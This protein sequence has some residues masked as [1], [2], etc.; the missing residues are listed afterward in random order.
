MCNYYALWSKQSQGL[1]LLTEPFKSI[2]F[3]IWVVDIYYIVNIDAIDLYKLFDQVFYPTFF[4]VS[5][6]PGT[7]RTILLYTM[8][9][10]E[11]KNEKEK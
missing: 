4:L 5:G 7:F 3:W 1:A 8:C 9:R 6:L 11:L 10:S 2:E